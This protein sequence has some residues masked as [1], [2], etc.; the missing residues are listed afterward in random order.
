MAD[1]VVCQCWPECRGPN[2]HHPLVITRS[3]NDIGRQ[4]PIGSTTSK[5]HTKDGCEIFLNIR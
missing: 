1:N 4:M 5:K 2:V 3:N